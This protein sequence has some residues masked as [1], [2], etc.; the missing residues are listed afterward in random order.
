T[1]WRLLRL[2][3]TG[4]ARAAALLAG[5]AVA[6][7]SD[8]ALAGRL[9]AAGL[10]HPRPPVSPRS[11]SRVVCV[12]PVRD[13]VAALDRCLD[14]LAGAEVVVVDDASVDAG[15]VASV[16]ASRGAR[17]VRLPANRGPAAARNAGC[18]AVDA[19]VDVVA[20]VDSDCAVTVDDIGRLAAH[21]A[22]PEVVAVA[23]RTR[24][25][26]A[27]MSTVQRF[28]ASRSPLDLGPGPA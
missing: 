18:A 22:D 27:P 28:A 8:A 6:D 1:P 20:F 26:G 4:A 24:P 21:L 17:L 12:V 14:A 11:A 7:R 19:D 23:P 2:T 15:A 5:G 16:A 10:A 25:A 13:R 9:V 3:P